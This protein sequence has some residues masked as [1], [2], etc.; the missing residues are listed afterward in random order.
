MDFDFAGPGC[1]F[2]SKRLSLQAATVVVLFGEFMGRLEHYSAGGRAAARG[3]V[4][5]AYMLGNEKIIIQ[6]PH[7]HAFLKFEAPGRRER[8]PAHAP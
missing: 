8:L 5:Y 1:C 4:N 6:I 3:R 2:G 7:D